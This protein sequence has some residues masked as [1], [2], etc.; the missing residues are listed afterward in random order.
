MWVAEL[1][2]PL[3]HRFEGFFGSRDDFDDQR[4]RG[5][6]RCPQCDSPEIER[7]LSAPR[8][9]LGAEAPAEPSPRER[10]AH[11]HA[12]LRATTEDVGPAFA[13]EARRI[14][15]GEAPQRG[16]RGRAS[17]EDMAALLDEGIAVMA[18]P[19]PDGTATTH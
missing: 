8:I 4:G 19:D 10:L 15:A 17:G 14:H 9:N 16:I 12:L 5:L 6:V 1:G 11:L 2:C 7:Q 13:A 3:G 18:L